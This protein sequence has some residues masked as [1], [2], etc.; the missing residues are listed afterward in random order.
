MLIVVKSQLEI[1]S[2][3]S[4]GDFEFTVVPHAILDCEGTI[5][6]LANQS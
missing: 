3:K 6:H 1:D 5:L 4:V 2:Q